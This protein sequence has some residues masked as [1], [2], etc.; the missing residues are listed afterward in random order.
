M[1]S[2]RYRLGLLALGSVLSAGISAGCAANAA[3]LVIPTNAP[4]LSAPEPPAR[5]IVP[6]PTQP[7]VPP[8]EEPAPTTTP[9]P[10]PRET[11]PARQT[12]PPTPPTDP[13]TATPPPVLRTNANSAEFEKRVRTQLA[14]AKTD[15]AAVTRRTLGADARAQYDSAMGFVRQAEEALKVKN[16]I[17]AGQLADKAAT[18]AALLRREAR[19]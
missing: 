15:L 2:A 14:K 6:A 1:A 18:M 8:T 9:T 5:V 12:P 11:P 7:T 3:P 10:R 17:Y 19:T 13:P 16:L 4:A